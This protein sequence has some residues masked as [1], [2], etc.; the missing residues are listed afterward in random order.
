M[1][2]RSESSRNEIGPIEIKSKKEKEKKTMRNYPSV[3]VPGRG[4]GDGRH[5]FGVGLRVD[6]ADVGEFVAGGHHQL[7][8]D[9]S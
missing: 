5:Y 2:T 3:F 1:V 9:L 7:A 8:F 6:A 4:G